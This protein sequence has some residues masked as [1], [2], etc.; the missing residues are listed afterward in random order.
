MSRVH[1]P[2][3][4][5]IGRVSHKLYSAKDKKQVPHLATVTAILSTGCCY[6]IIKS[7]SNDACFCQA[8]NCHQG[9][10]GFVWLLLVVFVELDYAS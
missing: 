4:V 2:N 6:V 5:Q 7:R 10:V 9:N 3:F 1:T 8:Y